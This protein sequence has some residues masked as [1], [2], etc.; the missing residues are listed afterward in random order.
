MSGLPRK[1]CTPKRADQLRNEMKNDIS[2]RRNIT[3]SRN[4]NTKPTG[5]TIVARESV[6]A[7]AIVVVDAVNA[8]ATAPA[9]VQRALVNFYRIGMMRDIEKVYMSTRAGYR[10]HAVNTVNCKHAR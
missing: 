10:K 3:T 5:L 6:V 1:K 2:F 7:Y 8:S 9:R 4:T